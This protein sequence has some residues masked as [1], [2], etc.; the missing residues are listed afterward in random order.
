MENPQAAVVK[1]KRWKLIFPEDA[2]IDK[3]VSTL[4]NLGLSCRDINSEK[5][6][7][8]APFWRPAEYF[9]QFF[10]ELRKLGVEVTESGS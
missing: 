1:A 7:E 4:L 9:T 3:E 10:N 5:R 2:D 8:V 6:V